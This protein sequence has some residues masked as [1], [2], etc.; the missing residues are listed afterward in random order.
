MVSLDQIRKHL[1][2]PPPLKNS[3]NSGLE[4]QIAFSQGYPFEQEGG[5]L[6][7]DNFASSCQVIGI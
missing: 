2:M 5:L 1:H 3:I 7:S 4:F 6:S